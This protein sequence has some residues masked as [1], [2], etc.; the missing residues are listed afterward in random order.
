MNKEYNSRPANGGN[1]NE[2]LF[3]TTLLKQSP[4]IVGGMN[5][6]KE[7]EIR[8]KACLFIANLTLLLN[9]PPSFTAKACLVLHRFFMRKS[10]TDYNYRVIAA[11]CL[12][13]VCKLEERHI[14]TERFALLC[15][16]TAERDDSLEITSTHCKNW[17]NSLLYFDD[18]V[19]AALCYDLHLEDPYEPLVEAVKKLRLS[20]DSYYNVLRIARVLIKHTMETRLCLLYPIVKLV[21]AC[22]FISLRFWDVTLS[23]KESA[24]DFLGAEKVVVEHVMEQ[25]CA[26]L[27]NLEASAVSK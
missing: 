22:V 26:I 8:Q 5:E 16:R 25:V 17:Y 9:G 21:S 18:E 12:L 4:S 6:E 24:L 19:L 23:S 13:I 10:L 20:G 14:R 1:A 3:S 11:T 2:W 7:V 15:A 27:P